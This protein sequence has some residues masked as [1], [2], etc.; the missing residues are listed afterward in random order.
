MQGPEGTI[1]TP[2]RYVTTHQECEVAQQC[3]RVVY[4]MQILI[5]LYGLGLTAVNRPPQ[6]HARVV[7]EPC[8]DDRENQR[9]VKPPGA[10][11][12]VLLP[13]EV[14]GGRGGETFGLAVVNHKAGENK[15]KEDGLLSVAEQGEKVEAGRVEIAVICRVLYESIPVPRGQQI[16][17]MANDDIKRSESAAPIKKNSGIARL[18]KGSLF[19]RS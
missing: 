7:E 17:C 4:W 14:E 3:Q 8:G 6:A 13:I 9:W 5:D 12:E 19:C 1:R 18:W 11:P 2:Y 15:E 10:P 16:S